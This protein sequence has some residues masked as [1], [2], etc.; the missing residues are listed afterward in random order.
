MTDTAGDTSNGH[1]EP[2]PS[3]SSLKEAHVALLRRHRQGSDVE[4]LD[5]AEEFLTRGSA[6]GVYLD[7]TDDR[8]ASQSLLDYWV[9][10]LYKAK[11]TPPDATL[12]EFDPQLSPELADNLC[13]YRGLNAFQ[14]EDSDLFFG[15]QRLV[16]QL[17]QKAKTERLLFVVGASGS[18]KSSL[19]LAG[20]IPILRNG[21]LEGSERWRYFPRMVPGTNPLRNLAS[22]LQSFYGQTA[23]W[24]AEQGR[25]LREDPRHLPNLLKD[26]DEPAVLIVDQF[27]EVFTLCLDDGLRESFVATLAALAESDGARHLAVI[28]MRTDYEPHL[29][30][31]TTLMPLLERGQVRITPLTAADLHEAIE[32]PARCIGLK[33]EDGIVDA[34]VK[35]ILGEPAGLPLLQF[36]LL[37]LWKMREDGRSRITWSSY[38]K[39]GGA[40]RALALTAD[41]FYEHLPEEKKITAKRI[42]LRMV[43]PSGTSEVMSNRVKRSSLSFEAQHRIDEVLDGLH[44]AGLVCGCGERGA[45][46]D[47]EGL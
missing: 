39:L 41:E 27:E 4:L 38:K 47:A 13:P 15:R 6:T 23:E 46:V 34:L 14:E 7:S 21:I 19:V 36:T 1:Q 25:L 11:R 35:D 45:R 20:L 24:A 16:E 17:V 12:A 33:F 37:R 2:Y 40:R 5:N 28:T 29:V 42:L 26:S 43:R 22:A 32:A 10:I 9:T 44:K 30:H 3:M 8:L 18:G 31:L